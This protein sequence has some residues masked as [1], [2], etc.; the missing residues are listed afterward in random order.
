MKKFN[1]IVSGV[2]LFTAFSAPV[3]A[4]VKIGGIVFTDFYYYSRDRADKEYKKT[5]GQISDIRVQIPS[6]SRFYARWTNED[7][8]GMYIEFGIGAGGDNED[9]VTLRHAYGWWD[10]TTQAQ[11]MAGKSTTPFSPLNPNVR[12]GTNSGEKHS[13]GV[14]YGNFYS[15]RFAQ[16]RFTYKFTKS[17]RLAIAMVDP[18]GK[19]AYN[20]AEDL[21]QILPPAPGKT[22]TDMSK[23]P[24]FDVGMPLYIGNFKL[25]PSLFYQKK[26]MDDVLPGVGD[27]INCWGG[28]FGLHTGF[29]P[30]SF[31]GEFNY[32]QNWGNTR[33]TIGKGPAAQHS[34]AT[35]YNNQLDDTSNLAY[36]LD[37]GFKSG[38]A[39]FHGIYGSFSS[40]GDKNPMEYT[41]QMYG[42]SVPMD[43]SKGFRIRPE[44]MWYDRGSNNKD[45]DGKSV[46]NGR[47]AIYGL[48]FQATF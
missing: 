10:I 24:R 31:E 29:G 36:W 12:I 25:Y 11:I 21:N 38:L 22:V 44:I 23:V 43:V 2:L 41:T 6:N 4:E 5:G 34:S 7:N 14:G 45:S 32:G 30:V 8:V 35:F 9:G 39:T 16:V 17:V 18:H 46:N 20:V 19:A 15:G 26:N 47:E 33:G 27:S 13:I 40:R 1:V 37:L 42:I 48:Q 28:S 3:I